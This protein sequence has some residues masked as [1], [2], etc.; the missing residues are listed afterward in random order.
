M[1][2][3]WRIGACLTAVACLF[4]AR[5]SAAEPI[6]LS[7]SEVAGAE[8]QVPLTIY[9]TADYIAVEPVLRAY[10]ALRPGL[11]IHYHELLSQELYQKVLDE[12]DRTADL[13]WS[14]AMDLQMKLVH[15]G[16]ARRFTPT[17]IDSLPEWS[18]WR[19]EAYAVSVEPAVMV[20]NR[21][22]FEGIEAPAT[23]EALLAW[24][25]RADDRAF[26]RVGT[27]DIERSGLGLLLAAR[28]ADQSRDFWTLVQALGANQ[29]ELFSSSSGLIER[30]ARGD[31]VLA[32]NVLGSYA[33]SR[34]QT[35][36]DLGVLLPRDYTLVI[37]RVALVPYAA[38][39]PGA[40]EDFLD[41]LLS[42]QGQ[43]ILNDR[44]GFPAV[45]ADVD[46]N[47]T[48]F[49]E[50]GLTRRYLEPM[51]VNT[52]LLVYLDQARRENVI[53]QWRQALGGP[54]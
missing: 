48:L 52:R 13:V 47:S 2:E 40:G 44:V 51:E 29:V 39:N 30:V 41:F 20:Y 15:D 4:L 49:P 6:V 24:L 18:Y 42:A 7:G 11:S 37:S 12:D 25:R 21:P 46:W 8:A 34:A 9:S 45:H 14:S 5:V 38:V 1:G 31:L 33:A 35:A 3:R 19:D 16:Y 53:R 26:Q 22:A 23:R 54:L 36:P 43:R 50:N 17:E 27:Y 10:Q 28:D 32:Y